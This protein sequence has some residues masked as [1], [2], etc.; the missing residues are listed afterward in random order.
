MDHYLKDLK[1]SVYE[2]GSIDESEVKTL[3]SV[4]A[5]GLGRDEVQVLLD[6]NTILSGSDYPSS[7]EDLFVDSLTTFA[8]DGGTTIS[9]DT[10]AWL[11]GHLLRDGTVDDLERKALQAIRAAAESVPDDL[12]ALAG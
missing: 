11:K 1:M 7:F 8:L 12:A 9:D 5:R 6:I 10:W 2:D 3:R 4:L